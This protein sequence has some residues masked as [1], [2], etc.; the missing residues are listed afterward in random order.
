M[1]FIMVR[2]MILIYTEVCLC[3]FS[4]RKVSSINCR[5]MEFVCVQH[6]PPCKLKTSLTKRNTLHQ[7]RASL[8]K[9]V[10]NVLL[11]SQDRILYFFFGEAKVFLKKLW[12]TEPT[13]NFL[14]NRNPV[15]GNKIVSL[16]AHNTM[17]Y[18]YIYIYIYIRVAKSRRQSTNGV[19]LCMSI[20]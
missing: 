17:I 12:F 20:A 15:S 1:A 19:Q 2:C 9:Q 13:T 16:I 5:Q 8:S 18:L 6:N 11:A 14:Y 10:N 7:K 4:Y 3:L